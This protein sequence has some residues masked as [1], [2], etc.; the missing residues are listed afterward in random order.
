MLGSF[1][2]ILS[3]SL[4]LSLFTSTL[5]S[6]RSELYGRLHSR[7]VR[8]KSVCTSSTGALDR[9]QHQTGRNEV[10]TGEQ[11]NSQAT[12]DQPNRLLTL[13][14]RRALLVHSAKIAAVECRAMARVHF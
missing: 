11:S 3:L 12:L 13:F 6:M 4:S 1:R 7:I 14:E 8:L 2:E 10:R 9:V 5:H